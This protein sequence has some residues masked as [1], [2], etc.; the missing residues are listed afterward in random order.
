MGVIYW[1]ICFEAAS[2]ILL[3]SFEYPTF[4]KSRIKERKHAVSKTNKTKHGKTSV[5]HRAAC[6][7]AN[8]VSVLTRTLADLQL[9][10]VIENGLHYE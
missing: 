1:P 3:W 7:N 4:C 10:E 5:S 9:V 8:H 6:W 2:L